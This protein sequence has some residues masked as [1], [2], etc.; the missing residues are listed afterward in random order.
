MQAT[1]TDQSSKLPI[2]ISGLVLAAFFVSGACGLIHEVAW[3]RLLRHIM[4]NTTFSI[5]TVLCA[6][7]GGLAL[8]SYLGGRFIDGR[9]D[10][11][12]VF[13]I[14]ELT[15]GVYC[16]LLPWFIN[17]AEPV[18]RFLYQNTHTSFYIFSLIRFL[19]S[20]LILLVPA[21]FMGATLPVLSR[22]LTRSPGVVGR[23][24]GTLYAI[25]TFGAVFG[26]SV[27]GFFLIP[28]LGVTNTIYL[29]SCF[30]LTIGG[31]GFWLYWQTRQGAET[32]EITQKTPIQQQKPKGKTPKKKKRSRETASVTMPTPISYSQ[33]VLKGMLVG[34]ALSG[35]AALV[36]EIAWFRVLSLLIGSTVYAFSLML[37]AFVLGI[38]IGSMV[39]ARFV[40]R[41]KN[42]MQALFII[43]LGIGGSALVF[44]PF[45]DQ[46]PFMVTGVLARSIDTFWALQA[47]QLSLCMGIMLI[48]TTLMGAAFPLASRIYNQASEN[49][50]RT[51]GN[52]YGANTVGNILG[53][54]IGGF[55]LIPMIGIQNT[56]FFAVAANI[57]VGCIFWLLMQQFG[58]GIRWAVAVA[59][60]LT[61]G[62]GIAAVPTWDPGR[63]S[64]GPY[65]TALRLS[66]ESVLS[67]EALEKMEARN[68]ILFHK[69]GLTT[70][71]TVKEV[72][73]GIRALYING[74]PDAS[75][76][77]TDLPHQEMLAHVPLM[78]HPQPRS[79]LVIGLASG[80]SVGSAG[81]HPLEEIDCVEISPA[82]V[83]ACRYFESYNYHILDDPRVNVIV[84]DGRNHM[85]LTDK[86]YDVIM[87]QPSNPYLAGVADLFTRE[88]FELC[89]K[90]L[91]EN[92]IMCTWM[93]AY[94]MDL[95]TFQSIVKTFLTVFPDMSIWRVGKT[96]CL[97]IGSNG[98]NTMQYDVLKERLATQKIAEDLKRINISRPEEFLLHKAMDAKGAGEFSGSALVHTDDNA[99]VEFSAPRS[100]SRTAFQLPLLEGMERHRQTDLDFLVPGS[101]DPALLAELKAVKET[102]KRYIEARGQVF[103][104]Y[105]HQHRKENQQAAVALKRAAQLNPGDSMLKEFNT[106]DHGRAFK[107]AKSGQMGQALALYQTMVQRVPGDEKAHYNLALAHRRM[108]NLPAAL[109]HYKEAVHWKPDYT[110]AVYNVGSVAEQMGDMQTAQTSYRKALAQKPDLIFALD[111]LAR[112]LATRRDIQEQ[113]P[114]EAVQLAEKA[115]QLTENKDPYVLETLGIAYEAAGRILEARGTLMQAMDFA[116]ASKDGRMMGRIDKRLK[117][118]QE[119]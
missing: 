66:K 91:N 85:L 80:I 102:S 58:K 44:V 32:D 108:G 40:D 34:Y 1:T 37:T 39:F 95:A 49:V 87:S 31:I 20:G 51:V 110:I 63:M 15:V 14:L 103:W 56:I 88:Y 109:R 22:F 38:A 113:T 119:K 28:A 67:V 25:N 5:T 82:M 55:I 13:A 100:L 69:E 81:R 76:A 41:I 23:S 30:N 57:L 98:S 27:S 61:T 42:P 50:G 29:A 4:G 94:K 8:G 79:A 114:G 46:L 107:L 105:I 68:K 83:E 19:F 52:V 96:D 9:K 54:F 97:L 117:N 78:F 6:F 99:L 112:L 35:F 18:Y 7:M 65:H 70:T 115:N 90:R 71:V 116:K 48:P 43:Q 24:V 26:A 104:T 74:K 47:V 59:I 64:F 45:V 53:S 106:G 62:L 89:R 36:Y 86:T 16:L 12:R 33:K 11:L 10:T 92:G 17:G 77:H 75:F 84:N 118:I 101:D 73:K 111:S 60:L 93:Q 2:R 3:T 21:I 72:A